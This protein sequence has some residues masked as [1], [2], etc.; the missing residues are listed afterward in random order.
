MQAK[1]VQTLC[2]KVFSFCEYLVLPL[3]S[4]ADCVANSAVFYLREIHSL[5]SG[6]KD[7]L[8]QIMSSRGTISDGNISEVGPSAGHGVGQM[9]KG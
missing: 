4:C 9:E 2:C 1:C 6:I 3:F 7:K 8:V 5:P